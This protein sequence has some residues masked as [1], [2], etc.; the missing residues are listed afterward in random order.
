MHA[1][2]GT[3]SRELSAKGAQ[4]KP[5]FSNTF[6]GNNKEDFTARGTIILNDSTSRGVSPSG[7]DATEIKSPKGV[8]EDE[9]DLTK[10]AIGSMK[11]ALNAV[12]HENRGEEIEQTYEQV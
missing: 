12:A 5:G 11:K 7:L 8:E 2:H 10:Q 9:T 4:F 3:L 1:A 6:L